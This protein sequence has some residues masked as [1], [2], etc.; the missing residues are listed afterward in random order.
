MQLG[1]AFTGY[2]NSIL[3]WEERLP[4]LAEGGPS[5]DFDLYFHCYP[6]DRSPFP[7]FL[8]WACH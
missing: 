4:L 8:G 1:S 2:L 5:P 6:G 7:I 3:S